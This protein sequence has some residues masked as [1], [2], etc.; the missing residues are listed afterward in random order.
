MIKI[1]TTKMDPKQNL[2]CSLRKICYCVFSKIE[3]LSCIGVTL[4]NF[5]NACL[6][7]FY[8]TC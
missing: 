5:V 4:P 3:Y 1:E 8:T 6:L 2:V 7:C